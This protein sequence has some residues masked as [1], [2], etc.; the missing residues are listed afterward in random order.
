MKLNEQL[1]TEFAKEI[2]DYSPTQIDLAVS[3]YAKANGVTPRLVK[4]AITSILR[5][6]DHKIYDNKPTDKE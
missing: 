2:K 6:N 4:R 3:N 1:L 5:R